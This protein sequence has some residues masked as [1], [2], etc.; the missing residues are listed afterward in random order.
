[1]AGVPDPYAVLGL[2]RGASLDEVKRAYRQ[3]AK[4]HHPDSAGERALPRFLEIQAAYEQLAGSGADGARAN[5]R[6]G[7]STPPRAP[8]Q[9]DETRADATRRAYGTRARRTT[10][11]APGGQ[12]AASGAGATPGKRPAGRSGRRSP[13]TDRTRKATLGSTSYDEATEEP[14]EPDWTGASWYGTSSGTYWTLNPREYADPRKHGPEY[15]ARARRGRETDQGELDADDG[16]GAEAEAPS[17]SEPSA[18]PAGRPEEVGAANW[19]ATPE[20]AAGPSWSAAAGLAEP[21]ER[22]G[23]LGG[24]AR[25]A[26]AGEGSS[27]AGVRR[28]LFEGAP[29]GVAGRFALALAGGAPIALGIAWL[30]GELTGCGRFAATCQPEVVSF[31]WVGGLAIVALLALLPSLAAAA[32]VGTV[33]ML[34]IGIPASVLL[35]ATGG[36]RLPQASSA[37]LGVIL[38]LGWLAGA[39]FA[40]MRRLR[41]REGR[42]PVS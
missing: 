35:S 42:G 33:A 19:R 8:W 27:L 1:M 2:P 23:R 15:Q 11:R 7:A 6:G 40:T 28:I 36:A 31:A 29:P 39:G 13:P 18:D 4:R 41:H 26:S 3:L 32:T 5:R 12:D 37:V 17:P 34:A 30:L 24:S 9:A 20:T 21:G 10:G 22:G 16:D 38:A 25:T 14:F